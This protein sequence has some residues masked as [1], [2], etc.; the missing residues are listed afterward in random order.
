[1]QNVYGGVFKAMFY[2]HP[3]CTSPSSVTVLC[4]RHFFPLIHSLG[5]GSS[6]GLFFV[7]PRSERLGNAWKHQATQRCR[8]I[9]QTWLLCG[10]PSY[11]PTHLDKKL[12]GVLYYVPFNNNSL[13]W[14][15]RLQA[16]II[17]MERAWC[18]AFPYTTQIYS[19]T[20]QMCIHGTVCFLLPWET[21]FDSTLSSGI[22]E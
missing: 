20:V 10:P 5:W 16:F 14:R 21:Y 12:Q 8:E 17:V 6:L 3:F 4:L 18:Q 2:K 7:S 22:E 19:F 13:Q 15:R 1:M 11:H 9:G